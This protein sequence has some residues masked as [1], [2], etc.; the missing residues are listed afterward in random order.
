[1]TWLLKRYDTTLERSTPLV[2]TWKGPLE[3]LV[4]DKRADLV[5]YAYLLTGDRASAEDLVHDAILRTFTRARRLDTVWEAHGYVKRTIATQFI[6]GTRKSAVAK[7]KE[8]LFEAA[9]IPSPAGAVG[10]VMVVERALATLSERHRAC[11]V[12]RYFDDLAVSEIAQILGIAS[13]TVKRYLHDAIRQ[14]EHVLGPVEQFH[15]TN[16]PT[17]TVSPRRTP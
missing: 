13:G 9:D 17:V 5:G 15:T 2:N 7:R 3:E 14:L 4:R 10:D 8:H 16:S 6:N 11:I 12:M 1:M